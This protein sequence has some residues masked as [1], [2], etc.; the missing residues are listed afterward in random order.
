MAKATKKEAVKKTKES[1][2][3]LALGKKNLIMIAIGFALVILGFALMLGPK[4]TAEFNPDIFSA[5][6]ISV[7]P[8]LALVGFVSV[9][10]AILWRFKEEE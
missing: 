7:G 2:K 5:R 1:K 8:M 3:N 4:S 10:F 9:I 6:R